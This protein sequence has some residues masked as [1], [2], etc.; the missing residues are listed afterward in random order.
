MRKSIN[1]GTLE[2][3]T[4][5]LRKAIASRES[6]RV[7]SNGLSRKIVF[8][9]G[10]K[11]NFFGKKDK[12]NYVEGVW[13]TAMVRK[14][15]D[16]Y[17]EKN[18]I[19][20][21]P[22]KVDVQLFNIPKINKIVQKG[23]RYPLVGVDINSC[24]WRTAFLLGYISEELYERGLK[25]CKKMGLLVAIGCLN[26]RPI[27]KEYID[28]EMRMAKHDADY[29]DRYSPFYW[30]IIY[31]TY[32]IMMEAYEEFSEDFV[33]YITDCLF[34]EMGRKNGAKL[35]FEERGYEC[36]SHIIDIVSYDGRQLIW[37][38]TK[39][40]RKKGIFAMNRDIS[41]QN[42]MFKISKGEI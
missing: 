11:Y 22:P 29:Y 38:D 10:I 23:K 26:K 36:K 28:G 24:Y 8:D 35:F 14:E 15:I 34:V 27:V 31:H 30:S 12:D 42:W 39:A 9:N 2:N 3:F 37:Y 20:P 41:L 32:K 13:L 18:G 4:D 25:T 33:M 5:T 21:T 6:F 16:A 1:K 19:P 7:V 40:N 17:I